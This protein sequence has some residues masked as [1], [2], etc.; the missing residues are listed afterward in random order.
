MPGA[1]EN[2]AAAIAPAAR[3]YTHRG[4]QRPPPERNRGE[5]TA[6]NSAEWEAIHALD[7]KLTDGLNLVHEQLGVIRQERLEDR[8]EF[9]EFRNEVRQ[10]FK[11]V[12]EETSQQ[13]E[14]FREETR[15]EFKAI[16]EETRQE[17]KA[18]REETRQQIEGLREDNR[19]QIEG[20]REDNRQQIEGL[21]ED[22]G[23]QIEGLREDTR[24]QIEGLREDTGR[25]I[26]GLR[27]DNR[28][29]IEGLREL[30]AQVGTLLERSRGTRR[31][32]WGVLGALGLLAAGGVLRPV[33][34]RVVAGVVRGLSSAERFRAPLGARC[35]PEA[36]APSRR[37][38]RLSGVTTCAARR[39]ERAGRRP[40]FP[41]GAPQP[42]VVRVPGDPNILGFGR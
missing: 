40:A 26:E 41:A 7:R 13:I 27:E 18:V 30:S 42:V 2:P 21:R 9:R 19:Q 20:L 6:V 11:A 8:R 10:E 35:R 14:G 31:L 3:P 29:L 34:D 32:V 24:Q 36:G 1:K 28:Q 4:G 33:F 39:A 12:R 25:Q 22:T 38:V 17:F 5:Q 37:A 23:R 15:Q 16:R